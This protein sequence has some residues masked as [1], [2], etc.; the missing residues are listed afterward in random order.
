M[1]NMNHTS[2]LSN[3]PDIG[4][5]KNSRL[6]ELECPPREST[7]KH[8]VV[9]LNHHGHCTIMLCLPYAPVKGEMDGNF[10]T[11]TLIGFWWL[12]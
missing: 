9:P 10:C 11:V 4:Y 2:H 12:M 5:S 3:L 8:R 7:E 1:I 6:V